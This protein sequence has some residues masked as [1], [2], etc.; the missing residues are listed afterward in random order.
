LGALD[1]LPE[2]H[3]ISNRLDAIRQVVALVA[4]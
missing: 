2:A 4:G 3:V 1:G